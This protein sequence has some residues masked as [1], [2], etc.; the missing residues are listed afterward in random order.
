MRGADILART[1][2]EAGTRHVFA[3]SGNQ[4]MPV[5]DAA[6]DA[7]LR[8]I[9][10]RHEGAAGFMAEGYAQITGTV[11]VALVTAGAGLGNAISPMITARA[12]QTPLLLMSGDSPVSRDGTGAFQEMDQVAITSS[13]TKAS[14][15]IEDPEQIASTLLE[16]LDIAQSGV[17]GP[18]H[19]ALPEDV[20]K[21]DAGKQVEREAQSEAKSLPDTSALVEALSTA[22]KPLVLA[23]PMFSP[24]RQVSLVSELLERSVPAIVSESPRGLN[25]PA[26]GV[27]QTLGREAD[28]VV[29][30]GKPVDF[31][32]GFG[33]E[34]AW[35]KARWIVAH[36]DPRE[37]DRARRN[38]GERLE[39]AIG[40]DPV[41]VSKALS[42]ALKMPGA[43][44]T[45]WLELVAELC[46][47]RPENDAGRVSAGAISPGMVAKAVMHSIDAQAN[48]ILVCDGGEFGQWAQALINAPKRVINGISGAIGGGIG[49]AMGARAALPDATVFALMGDGTAGFHLPEFETAA[50]EKLPFIAII[51]NDR[52]WNA[53]HLIQ[54]R[55]YG[56]DR[57]HG[58]T[59]SGARYDQAVAALGGFGVHVTA[60]S[61]L[62]D[63]IARSAE[64]VANG[65]PACINVEIEGLP[66]PKLA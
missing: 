57:M 37:L 47:K 31:T 36:D 62:D 4:I 49:Y 63:A 52:K 43:D 30:L 39:Q 64:A 9:H 29:L 28:L 7:Q 26:L 8:F 45:Q 46:A 38:L 35:P 23:G 61:Q 66:A 51:G 41:A 21:A 16:L 2:H 25:D 54:M 44:R 60:Q 18:V 15:R 50:R 42:S 11:G 34:A 56:N 55:D 17:P 1:L 32:L 40:D 20:M 27:W 65:I 22:Q 58:C 3:L 33:S 10:T 53:E 19:L 6:P 14:R 59:L 24:R 12:S 5:F 13:L 48:P